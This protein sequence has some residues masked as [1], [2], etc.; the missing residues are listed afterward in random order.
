MIR[1]ILFGIAVCAFA[2]TS[3]GPEDV[4]LEEAAVNA[5]I[6]SLVG[7]RM[8]EATRR[9][10]ED[11]DRRQAIEVKVKTDSILDARRQ[12]SQRATPQSSA[13]SEP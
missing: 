13:G 11:L 7:L 8:E 6:D 12:T 4:V 2:F 3:C 5:K 1:Q 10:A 9:A